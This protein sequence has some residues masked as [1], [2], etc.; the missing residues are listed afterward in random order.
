MECEEAGTCRRKAVEAYNK[1][2]HGEINR[3]DFM[4]RSHGESPVRWA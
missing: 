4:E 2:I 3:R 1:Y